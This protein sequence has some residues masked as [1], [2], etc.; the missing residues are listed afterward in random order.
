MKQGDV[1]KQGDVIGACGNSGASPAPHIHMQMQ[2]TAGLPTPDPLP[3]QFHDYM[4]NGKLVSIGEP[5]KGQLVSNSSVTS[6]PSA[7]N[8][9]P[10]AEPVKK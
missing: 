1:V 5:S 10:K 9:A 6:S 7:A 3:A 4:A 2:N 8:A